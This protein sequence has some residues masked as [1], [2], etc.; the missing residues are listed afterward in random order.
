MA[1]NTSN[2]IVDKREQG[3]KINEYSH[4]KRMTRKDK[5]S[6][7]KAK[8]WVRQ[9]IHEDLECPV[10]L[11]NRAGDKNRKRVNR[12]GDMDDE[13][14]DPRVWEGAV[15]IDDKYKSFLSSPT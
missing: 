2:S 7:E 9:W 12:R 5:V 8:F 6:G 1:T 4:P 10:T 13:R 3:K 15:T 14:C 11:T